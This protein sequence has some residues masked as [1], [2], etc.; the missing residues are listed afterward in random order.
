MS[1]RSGKKGGNEA[2]FD[3]AMTPLSRA[4]NELHEKKDENTKNTKGALIFYAN[5]DT[6]MVVLCCTLAAS[7]KEKSISA[8]EQM[9]FL[10]YIFSSDLCIILLFFLQPRRPLLPLVYQPITPMGPE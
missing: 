9:D 8:K 2:L 7:I 4:L 5:H 6:V 10:M 1:W 3:Q